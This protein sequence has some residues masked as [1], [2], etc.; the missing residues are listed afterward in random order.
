MRVDDKIKISIVFFVGIIVGL[1]GAYAVDPKI[2]PV[3]AED[4]TM[5][6]MYLNHH[7]SD[8]NNFGTNKFYV[9]IVRIGSGIR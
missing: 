4:T 1:Y 8:T 6:I 5:T 9:P 7:I 3:V 2:D